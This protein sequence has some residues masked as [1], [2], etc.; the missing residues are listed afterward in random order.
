DGAFAFA[1]EI[2]A[3]L[4]HP[5]F[6]VGIDRAGLVEYFTFQNFFTDRTLFNNVRLL[7]AGTWMRVQPDGRT[8]VSR[9]W[10]Y[11]FVEPCTPP[12]EAELLETLD[13]LFVRAVRRQLV[14]DVEV[15]AYLSG[16]MDSGSITAIAAR[17]FPYLKSFTCGFDV[18]SASGIEQVF[19]ERAA[20]ERMSA[21]YR[22][23]HYEM[24]LKSGDM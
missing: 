23:E 19:D 9:Y 7:P 15:G 14:S 6:Q 11:D 1:S 10:D 18:S 5:E 8:A 24:V 2:K 17:E 3:F 16:G 13:Q 12:D 20:A 21:R 22:T 4:A